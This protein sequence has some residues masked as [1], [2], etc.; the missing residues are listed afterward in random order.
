MLVECL[1]LLNIRGNTKCILEPEFSASAFGNVLKS[2]LPG[3]PH[4][5]SSNLRHKESF[6]YTLLTAF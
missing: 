4:V 3:I 5:Q 1:G 2:P 6:F